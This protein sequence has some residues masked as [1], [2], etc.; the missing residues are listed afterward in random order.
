MNQDIISAVFDTRSEAEAAVA[1]LRSEGINTGK[2]SL[3]GRDEGSA[4]MTD[5]SGNPPRKA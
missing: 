5:G 2:L 1:E 3:I 4:N